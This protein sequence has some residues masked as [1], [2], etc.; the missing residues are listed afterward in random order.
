MKTVTP[1]ILS[2]ILVLGLCCALLSWGYRVKG[3]YDRVRTGLG[4]PYRLVAMSSH[5]ETL[6]EDVEGEW[7]L[8]GQ[9]VDGPYSQSVRVAGDEPA[10]RTLAALLTYGMPEYSWWRQGRNRR[11]AKM[12]VI[13]AM[14]LPKSVDR[15]VH[16]SHDSH[17]ALIRCTDR[18]AYIFRDTDEGLRE[19]FYVNREGVIG[20][21]DGEGR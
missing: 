15:S 19:S 9:S 13:L 6:L 11:A 20:Q 18:V 1:L 4:E 2:V 17:V 10:A 8:A 12:A 14:V 16:V 7:D 21:K 5:M 3:K